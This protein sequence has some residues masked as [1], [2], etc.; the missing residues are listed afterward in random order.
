M[1][2]QTHLPFENRELPLSPGGLDA[3]DVIR[4]HDRAPQL[5]LGLGPIEILPAAL[6]TLIS[7]LDLVPLPRALSHGQKTQ[8]CSPCFHPHR[9]I[10]FRNI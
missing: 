10:L 6:P 9:R 5:D 1:G 8:A 4:L 2:I 3:A 7:A